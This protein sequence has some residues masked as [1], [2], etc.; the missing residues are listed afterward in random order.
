MNGIQ[1][2]FLCSIGAES[3]HSHGQL[4]GQMA[5]PLGAKSTLLNAGSVV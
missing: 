5:L 1:R 3:P 2:A 4:M